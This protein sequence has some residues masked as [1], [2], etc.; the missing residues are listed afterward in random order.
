ME[1]VNRRRRRGKQ[2]FVTD[3]EAPST[4]RFHIAIGTEGTDRTGTYWISM[5]K[6]IQN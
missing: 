4:G 2:V 5:T 6:K 1:E 3:W